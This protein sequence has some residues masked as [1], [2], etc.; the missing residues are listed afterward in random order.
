MLTLAASLTDPTKVPV[1]LPPEYLAAGVVVM[2]L[3][4]LV[5]LASGIVTIWDR[6]RKKPSLSQD[7]NDYR[8][9]AAK[10]F[11]TKGELSAVELRISRILDAEQVERRESIGR[12]EDKLQKVQESLDGGFKQ[13]QRALGRVEGKI[14]G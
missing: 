13:I 7:L 12:V 9:E 3:T 10:T 1:D 5:S 6:T 11:A 14:G 8:H 2:G 4:A